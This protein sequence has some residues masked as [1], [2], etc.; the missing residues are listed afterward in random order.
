MLFE[1]TGDHNV[2]QILAGL[3]LLSSCFAESELKFLTLHSLDND[4]RAKQDENDAKTLSLL[5]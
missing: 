4:A 5:Q 3:P 1:K 2:G